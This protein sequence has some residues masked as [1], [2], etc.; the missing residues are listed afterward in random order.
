MGA[1]K[2]LRLQT[3][4]GCGNLKL[5]FEIRH[6]CIE[7][8]ETAWS[9]LETYR[10]GRA[11]FSDVLLGQINQLH[12]CETTITLDKKASEADTFQLLTEEY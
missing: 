9:A 3:G 10:G 11:D 6:F 7:E 1:G 12:G 4:T 8:A 5:I 2:C